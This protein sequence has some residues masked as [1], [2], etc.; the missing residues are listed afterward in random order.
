MNV[1]TYDYYTA[2]DKYTNHH[3]PLSL[4]PGQQVDANTKRLNIDWTINYYLS[5]GAPAHKLIVGVPTYGRSYTLSRPLGGDSGTSGS[6]SGPFSSAISTGTSGEDPQQLA[7]SIGLGAR[8]E[9]PGDEGPATREKGYLAYYEICQKVDG[10]AW[11]RHKFAP[12][13]QLGPVA[14]SGNQWVSYDDVE[15]AV[16]KAEYVARRKLGGVMVWTLDNDDFRAACPSSGGVES[17]LIRAVR[18]TIIRSVTGASSSTSSGASS[19][20]SRPPS[21][22]TTSTSTTT[23]TTTTTTTPPPSSSQPEAE[24]GNELGNELGGES[25]SGSASSLIRSLAQGAQ[26][27]QTPSTP[28]PSA[29]FACKDEGFFPNPKDCKK[30]FWCLDSGPANLGLVAHAFTCPSGLVF[31]QQTEGC[32]YA[33]KVGCRRGV[34]RTTATP[35][36]AARTTS[37]ARTTT[38]TPSVRADAREPPERNRLVVRKNKKGSSSTTTTTTTTTSTTT[39]TTT[40]PPPPTSQ[41]SSSMMPPIPVTNDINELVASMLQ[42]PQFASVISQQ[43][44]LSQEQRGQSNSNPNANGEPQLGSPTLLQHNRQAQFSGGQ[45]NGAPEDEL[46]QAGNRPQDT[47]TQLEAAAGAG[48]E[49]DQAAASKQAQD[50]LQL[51]NLIQSLGGVDKIAPSLMQQA[52]RIAAGEQGGVAG[53]QVGVA[54]GDPNQQPAGVNQRRAGQRPSGVTGVDMAGSGSGSGGGSEAP[55]REFVFSY[56]QPSGAASAPT[57]TADEQPAAAGGQEDQTVASGQPQLTPEVLHNIAQ[58]ESLFAYNQPQGAR[59]QQPGGRIEAQPFTL[60]DAKPGLASLRGSVTSQQ[61]AIRVQVP[62]EQRPAGQQRRNQQQSQGQQSSQQQSS[63][64]QSQQQTARTQHRGRQQSAQ[65]NTNGQTELYGDFH[66]PYLEGDLRQ[67]VGQRASEA[68]TSAYKPAARPQTVP[69]A[70]NEPGIVLRANRK[71]QQQPFEA[72]SEFAAPSLEPVGEPAPRQRRPSQQQQQPPEHRRRPPNR[73]RGQRLNTID[74]PPSTG[75]QPST[76]GNQELLGDAGQARPRPRS[77][78]LLTNGPPV[79]TSSGQTTSGGRSAA[80]ARSQ[81][82]FEERL[83]LLES[84]L[85]PPSSLQDIQASADPEGAPRDPSGSSPAATPTSLAESSSPA[86]ST[87]QLANFFYQPAIGGQLSVAQQQRQQQLQQLPNGQLSTTTTLASVSSSGPPNQEFSSPAT[88][89]LL[90]EAAPTGVRDPQ[91]NASA[92][93]PQRET[94]SASPAATPPSEGGPGASL[95]PETGRLLCNR[96]GVFAHPN[97][98]GQFIVCAPQSRAQKSLRPFEH[99]CPAEHIFHVSRGEA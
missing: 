54:A 3:A 81:R 16:M 94:S 65:Y 28:E 34:A 63:Q 23:T 17:P 55:I 30:Y 43:L 51:L 33:E 9:G 68:A 12:D 99:H 19:T 79:A 49:A 80:E 53:D 90:E 45:A 69:R 82:L 58:L 7:Q 4:R 74:F 40:T 70:P 61:P 20:A 29:A 97:S 98:C 25:A 18:D 36:P 76:S 86:S 64:Q 27:G 39:T 5:L 6:T 89:P 62:R 15:A 52:S 32:D 60:D 26:S 88:T 96:R 71:P 47:P 14:W 46:S 77:L 85:V 83:R 48:G 35:T 87:E 42:N 38:P 59:D 21:S 37:A 84:G 78:V 1:L 95:D 57:G 75:G 8:A 50:L 31:N 56:S 67:P 72:S 92:R 91:E 2:F 10:E 44:K 11:Q 73:E 24:L 13:E 93:P 22:S 66:L 41:A